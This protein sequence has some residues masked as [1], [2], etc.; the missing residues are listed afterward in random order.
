MKSIFVF[1]GIAGAFL[2]GAIYYVTNKGTG[3]GQVMN[4][5]DGFPVNA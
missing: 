4:V 5:E 1:A 3:N 2:A